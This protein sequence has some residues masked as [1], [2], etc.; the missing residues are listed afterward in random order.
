MT[1]H[2]RRRIARAQPPAAAPPTPHSALDQLGLAEFKPPGP[3]QMLLEARAPWE[4]AAMLAATPW[5]RQI[6]GGD[7]HVVLVFPGLGASDMSTVPLRNFLADRGW[8]PQPWKQ[9][10]NFGPRH[11]VLDSCRALVAQ[12]F[13]RSGAKVSLLGWSLGGVYARELA[14]EQPEHVRCVITLGSPFSGHPRGTNA[15]RFYQMVSGQQVEHDLELLAQLA[16]PPAVPTTSIYSQTDGVVAWQCSLNPDLPHTENIEVH[17]SH[18]GMGMNPLALYAIAD[19]LRQDPQRWQR[20]DPS[21][22]RRW[23]YKTTHHAPVRAAQGR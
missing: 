9:G 1:L 23:F 4:Y 18:I 12:A 13:E 17:A 16:E 6:P 7:G 15:F 5:L 3:L 19:R 8:Q 20:F 14:K 22:A 11:G 2:R 21:G 10:F